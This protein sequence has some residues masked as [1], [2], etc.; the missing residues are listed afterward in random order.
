MFF[1]F[2]VIPIII[3]IIAYTIKQEAKRTEIIK[4]MA[5]SL[6]FTFNPKPMA[7]DYPIATFQ[8]FNIGHSKRFS[9]G[10]TQE[11]NGVK[12]SI[13]EY[14]YT[15]GSGKNSTT[16]R[17]TV[18]LFSTPQLKLPQFMLK[19]EGLF[20]KIGEIFGAKDIDFE[21]S[22]AFSKKY[23]LKSDIENE[24]RTTFSKEIRN[25][26]SDKVNYIIEGNGMNLLMHTGK[27]TD[28]TLIP[29]V[30]QE[31][32]SLFQLFSK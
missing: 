17:Q 18:T 29:E 9:N 6:G 22:P 30:L 2:I 14:F 20:H 4:N 15:T 8:L 5:D 21:D 32:V 19:P 24:T 27:R 3:L 31:Q 7:E 28:A 12:I 11:K 1:L 25:F 16:Y 26:L 10:M 13:F 23:L